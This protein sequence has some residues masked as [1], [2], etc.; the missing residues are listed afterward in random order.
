MATNQP[1]GKVPLH[2][3]VVILFFLVS[4]A[5]SDD[6]ASILHHHVTRFNRTLG[7]QAKSMYARPG[8]RGEGGGREGGKGQ[9]GGT[10]RGDGGRECERE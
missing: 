10:V 9:E 2:L 1:R 5:G 4:E 8:A 3:S 7:V 6:G